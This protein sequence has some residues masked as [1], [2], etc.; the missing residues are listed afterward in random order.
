MFGHAV[1]RW[2]QGKR[3]ALRE[4]TK[5][6]VLWWDKWTGVPDCGA[7]NE[8]RKESNEEP[9]RPMDP[10]QKECRVCPLYQHAQADP[11][12]KG[13]SYVW[14]MAQFLSGP[15]VKRFHIQRHAL[16][17]LDLDQLDETESLDLI[18]GLNGIAEGEDSARRFLQ[19]EADEKNKKK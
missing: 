12:P 16:K 8:L 7:C 18:E 4:Y 9:L 19:K 5:G 11:V 2:C 1:V 3:V 13:C 15:G 17:L 14:A 6:Q 10:S